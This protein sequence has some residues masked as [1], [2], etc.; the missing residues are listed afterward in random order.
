M[1]LIGL[2]AQG[3]ELSIEQQLDSLVEEVPG[4]TEKVDF[5]LVE[6]PISEF[7]RAVAET[8]ELN[9]SFNSL[10]QIAITNNFTNVLV[11]DLLVFL[12]KEYGLKIRFTNNIFTFYADE[13]E[14]LKR[15]LVAMENGL[16]TINARNDRLADLAQAITS[17]SDY[18]LIVN[19]MVTEQLVN[20][21]IEELPIE[22]AITNLVEANNLKLEKKTEGVYQVVGAAGSGDFQQGQRPR[23]NN[24]YRSNGGDFLLETYTFKGEH[25]VS[26]NCSMIPAGEIIKQ[27]GERLDLS[28]F[29][30]NE[31]QGQLSCRV[32]SISLTSFLDIALETSN[33]TYTQSKDGVYMIGELQGKLLNSAE[34]YSFKNRTVEGVEELIPQTLLQSVELKLFNDLNALII[35]GSDQSI[36]RVVSFLGKI[37]RPVPNVMIEVM[38]IEVRK[39]YQLN[40]GIK[41]FLSDSVPATSGQ[42]FSGVDVTLSSQSFNRFLNNLDGRGILNLGRVTPNFYATIE[43]ME[44]NN[45]LNIRSTPKL[46][47]LNGHEATMTIGQSVYYLVETQ[48]VTGGVTPVITRTP[49]YEKVEA[50]LDLKINPFVS[51]YEDVTM[52]IEAEFS[53]FIPPTVQGAPPGNATRKFLS[54]IRVKNEEMVVLGG[55]EEASE[56]NGGS[57]IPV[58]SRIPILKW[59]FS[60]RSEEKSDNKLLIFIKPTIVY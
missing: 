5:T 31:P 17:I 59:L 11:K 25:F 7:I 39:I 34:V 15:D 44:E 49:R 18:N 41:A 48:N 9:V 30:I 10:P 6:A 43:A 22:E 56:S 12:C 4:L 45:D 28:F 8:H 55:L 58:L 57:G 14:P 21:Y 37:D 42:I 35:S 26:L 2:N 19:Q 60:S 33:Q 53:D 38:V 46:S 52:N 23:Y 27:V 51:D 50:N 32:D 24:N 54:K 13:P 40:T 36:G 16:I 29:M 47:T 3:Q 20:A 1:V